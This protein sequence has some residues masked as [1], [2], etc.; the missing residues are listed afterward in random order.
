MTRA[1]KLKRWEEI[2]RLARK[3]MR[4]EA[5]RVATNAVRKAKSSGRLP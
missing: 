2:G 4:E 1:E 5:R 3:A